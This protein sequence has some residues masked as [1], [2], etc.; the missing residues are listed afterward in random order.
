MNLDYS[1]PTEEFLLLGK[2]AKAH[3]MRGEVKIFSFSGQPENIKAYKEIVLVNAAGT[4]S[5]SLA[6]LGCRVQGKMAITRLDSITSRDKAESIEKMGVLIAKKLLP[7]LEE[8]EFYWHHYVGKIVTDLKKQ[9]I[10]I[11]EN[12]F[13]NGS[14]DIMVIRAGTQEI[15]I[16]ISKGIVVQE[17]GDKISI[18]PPPGLLELYSDSGTKPDEYLSG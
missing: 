4:L 14:Q 17:D 15:L 10:G 3:G 2:V 16:P 1:F 11:I 5:T 6:V 8:D 9:N 12:I 7:E 13:S 18:D